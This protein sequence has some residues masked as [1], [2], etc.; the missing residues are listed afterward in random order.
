MRILVAGAAGRLGGVVSRDFSAAGHQVSALYR[1]HLDITDADQVSAA[2]RVLRPN[3]IVNC[4]AFNSVDAAET[5]VAQAMAINARGPAILA[6]AADRCGAVLIHFSTDFVFDGCSGDPYLESDPPNP[7]SVYGASKL[8]GELEV[9]AIERHYIL[10]LESLFGGCGVNGHRATIDYVIDTLIACQ[11]VRAFC[12]RTVSPSYVG[13]V[14]LATSALIGRAAPYGTYHCVN[15]GF[16][17]W[18][19][20]AFEIARRLRIHG[21]ITPIKSAEVLTPA[22]RPQFCALSNDKLRHQGIDMP[23]WQDALDRHITAREVRI[24]RRMAS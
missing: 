12:D 16:T 18:S 2:V 15:S 19:D 9:R 23:T 22:K 7:L 13:D 1:S 11:P 20:L 14:S 21:R 24:P 17:T 10:R 8:A 6:K 3:V 4:V 5:D